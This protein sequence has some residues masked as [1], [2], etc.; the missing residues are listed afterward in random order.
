VTDA[1]TPPAAG[2]PPET[3]SLDR[4]LALRLPLSVVLAG[5]DLCV[6]DVLQ[7]RPGDVLEFEKRV[8]DPLEV[9]INQ[10]TIARGTAVK[11]GERFAL[12]IVRI[13]T[14]EETVRLLGPPA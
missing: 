11:S 3:R 9:L 13:L 4:I 6:S 8:D 1:P 7:L 2:P 5:K 12:K 10:K 14:A